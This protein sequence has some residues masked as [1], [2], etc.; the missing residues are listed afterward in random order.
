MNQHISAALLTLLLLTFGYYYL[1]PPSA[2]NSY[3]W[4]L[5]RETYG[6]GS[7]DLALLFNKTLY[8]FENYT[9]PT[10]FRVPDD[11]TRLDYSAFDQIKSVRG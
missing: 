10:I 4:L 7:P 5:K 6:K 2:N 9:M 11:A 1:A 3:T 8:Y